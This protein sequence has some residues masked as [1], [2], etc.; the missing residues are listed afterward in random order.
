MMFECFFLMAY[1]LLFR[2]HYIVLLWLWYA[3]K[4]ASS[5]LRLYFQKIL[6]SKKS[7]KK[8]FWLFLAGPTGLEPA[9]SAVTGRRS[10]P[11]ELRSRTY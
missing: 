1:L 6:R 11:T 2:C 3:E 8:I 9:T 10:K 7:H 4:E 5:F